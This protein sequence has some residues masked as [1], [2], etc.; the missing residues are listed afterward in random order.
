MVYEHAGCI[1]VLLG[2]K[3]SIASWGYRWNKVETSK[4]I[5]T[6]SLSTCLENCKHSYSIFLQTLQKPFCFA[7]DYSDYY[8]GQM[9]LA[10]AMKGRKKRGVIFPW[11][12]THSMI[13]FRGKVFE[14]GINKSYYMSRDPGSCKITWRR[15]W[16]S[17]S[18]CTLNDA[19]TW[20]KRYGRRNTYNIVFNNCHMFVNRLSRY[21][22]SDCGRWLN[23]SQTFWKKTKLLCNTSSSFSNYQIW[24]K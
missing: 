23:L 4:E 7:D 9:S 19:V 3:P 10:D 18:K 24:L 8:V 1:M 16:A 22:Y 13:L 11:T 20:T 2:K 12:L 5:S 21:L 15:R 14:W 6:M 17:F